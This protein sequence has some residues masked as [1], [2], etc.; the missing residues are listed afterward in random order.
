MKKLTLVLVALA[1][2]A[3][4][5]VAEDVT[6][7][8]SGSATLEW[9]FAGQLIDNTGSFLDAELA[10]GDFYSSAD[11][12]ALENMAAPAF[13]MMLSVEDADG[14]V[15][16]E[17][18]AG[19]I[20]LDDDDSPAFI[21][22]EA[23][24]AVFDYISFPNVVPGILG[25]TL[26]GDDVLEP[27]YAPSGGVTANERILVDITPMG[28]ALDVTLGLLVKPDNKLMR[29]YYDASHT[30]IATGDFV[31]P[32]NDDDDIDEVDLDEDLDASSWEIGTYL[33]WAASLEA[34][35][36]Q[37]L[38]MDGDEISV[39][40]GTVLDAGFTSGVYEPDYPIDDTKLFE[41]IGDDVPLQNELGTEFLV[42]QM[43][44]AIA[45]NPLSMEDEGHVAF[46]GD[47]ADDT[48]L[49]ENE[50]RGRTTIPFGAMVSASIGDLTA[51]VDFQMVLAEGLDESNFTGIQDLDDPEKNT[52][53]WASYG[54]P[55]Y[56]AVDVGYE[57]AVGDMTIT[58]GLNF[59][60]S[61]DFWKWE[62][63]DADDD[64]DDIFVYAGDVS[65]ADFIGRPMSLDVGVDVEGIAGMID[66]GISASIALG[67]GVGNHGYGIMADAFDPFGMGLG[68]G[69][70]DSTYTVT[71]DEGAVE[72]VVYDNTLAETLD[73]WWT[74]FLAE[75]YAADNF[76][77]A[78]DE[79]IVAPTATDG[80]N[81]GWFAS[82]TSAMGIELSIAVEPIDGLTIENVT[83]YDIDNAGI[84]FPDTVE[85]LGFMPWGEQLSSLS[86]A[87]DIEYAW[88][89]GDAVA[90]TIF[91]SFTYETIGWTMEDGQMVKVFRA[92]D[93]DVAADTLEFN[94]SE[95]P[96]MATF[97]YAVGV[98]C[99]VAL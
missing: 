56:A 88:M 39:G 89:M 95:A 24:D 43:Y 36:T 96:S 85:I 68:L 73:F 76:W 64:E 13:T 60:Y 49:R 86:N 37:E 4:M 38:G 15:F 12:E 92:D 78:G 40:I 29:T 54:M 74:Q 26:W 65:A 63:G 1:F 9:G 58:P 31:F 7:S 80:E 93:A 77:T 16:V 62:Q 51:G 44:G 41:L 42:D 8:V 6:L 48:A 33:T 83:N 59:K 98:K 67:D 47:A 46:G 27:A 53:N 72:N 90:F 57:L 11:E 91:G 87:T 99:D 97:D 10:S 81:N 22:E 34:T 61:S 75:G 30:A 50:I 21:W 84:G 71:H 82:G 55:M 69:M 17:A 20:A 70:A 25:I 52:Y 35:F 79:D 32:D 28:D 66:V 3:G 19:E 45:V 23:F 94:Y 14:N 18:A 5:A 2:V